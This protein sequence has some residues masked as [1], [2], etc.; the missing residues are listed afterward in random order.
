MNTQTFSNAV[1]KYLNIIASGKI[2]EGQIISMRSLLNRDKDASRAIFEALGDRELELSDR[3]QTKGF[4]FLKGLWKSPTG[5]ERINNPFG[6]REQD[7]L[8]NGTDITL[9]GFYNASVY[10][11]C[12]NYLPIYAVNSA[13]GSFEYYYNGKLQIIG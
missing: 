9:K 4:D 12:D 8:T 2:E 7:I 1:A 10:G 5:K 11:G 6:Y 13:D 3:Q